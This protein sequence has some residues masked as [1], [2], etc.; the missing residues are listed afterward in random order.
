MH[1][2]PPADP[3]T[4]LLPRL[5]RRARRLCTCPSDADDLVQDCVLRLWARWQSHGE[6]DN[7]EAYAMT[8]LRHRNVSL[9]RRKRD[10]A[11]LEETTATVPPTALDHLT[12]GE[13]RAAISDLPPQQEEVLQ[14]VLT[15]ETRPAEIA[16]V[17][18]VPEGTVMSRLARARA[19]LR[20]MH[21][22]LND[23]GT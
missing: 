18:D 2:P 9:W 23:L 6:I 7:L 19:K 3:I 12:L 5:Q 4:P 22:D 13:V 11:A 21:P 17:L 14:Q 1:A 10:M 20:Q 8:L 15:G 16:A